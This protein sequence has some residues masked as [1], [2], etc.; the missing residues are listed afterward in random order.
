MLFLWSPI[1]TLI[2]NPKIL[3]NSQHIQDVS[4]EQI[5][6]LLFVYKNKLNFILKVLDP[7]NI[8]GM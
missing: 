7:K 8:L 1:I 5:V 3:N 2:F 4:S 6:Y